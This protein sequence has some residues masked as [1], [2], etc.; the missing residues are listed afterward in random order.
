MMR[1][2][3][4]LVLLVGASRLRAQPPAAAINTIDVIPAFLQLWKETR[5]ATSDQRAR[6]FL[7]LVVRPHAELFEGFTG[8]VS[9]GRA[10]LYLI[11]VERFVPAIEKLHQSFVGSFADAL[12]GFHHALPGFDWQGSV[13]LMPN[14]FGFDGGYGSID[15]RGYLVFGLDTIARMDGPQADLPVLFMHELFHLYH[16]ALHPEWKGESRGKDAP[17]FRLVWGEGLATY[18]SEQLRPQ[19]DTAAILRSP[20]LAAA[21]EERLQ[22][23][24]RQLL[25]AL[26]SA[27]Q[28]PFMEWM[29]G[30]DRASDVPPRAGYY[31][32][33]RIARQL[34]RKHTL[35]DLA[36]LASAD[37]RKAI[38]AELASL[39][40]A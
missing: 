28:D 7:E 5:A 21:C 17:L 13:V 2:R 16:G 34:G 4:A 15:G 12:A 14:L 40:Q 27:E 31:F 19:A 18:A 10:G 37:I 3:Q 11:Q 9:L 39:A 22:P 6:R 25:Q 29:S 1:R 33:W 35:A 24:A 38:A 30:R 26:D 36:R 20:T 8:S 23:L 32:G